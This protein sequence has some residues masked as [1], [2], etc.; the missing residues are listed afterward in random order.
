LAEPVRTRP[1]EKA[2]EDDEMTQE[3]RRRRAE[4]M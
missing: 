2:L 1:L 4:A 3:L